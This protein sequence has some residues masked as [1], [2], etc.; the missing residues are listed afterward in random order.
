MR[1]RE[2]EQEYSLKIVEHIG[3]ISQ[4]VTGWNKELNIIN[5][6]GKDKYDIRDWDENHERLSRGVT[7][8]A[9]EM[10]QLITL[11]KKVEPKLMEV[12]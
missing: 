7:L 6:G 12:E 9:D 2:Q 10:R 3:V 11:L 8:T 5:W 4:T 1:P